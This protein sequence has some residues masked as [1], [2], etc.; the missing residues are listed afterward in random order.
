MPSRRAT[1]TTSDH[2][3]VRADVPRQT[4]GQVAVLVKEC[5][6]ASEAWS[7]RGDE[8]VCRG[9]LGEGKVENIVRCS[10]KDEVKGPPGES[11]AN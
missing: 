5:A 3:K 2:S 9:C 6:P 7:T 11:G 4:A 8:E 10:Y 1:L